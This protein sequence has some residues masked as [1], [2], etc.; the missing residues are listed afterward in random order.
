MV[1][2]CVGAQVLSRRTPFIIF[3]PGY[4]YWLLAEVLCGPVH[5]S[6]HEAI[7]TTRHIVKVFA[8]NATIL[9]SESIGVVIHVCI[10]I[11]IQV[12]LF[13]DETRWVPAR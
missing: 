12:K 11:S 1:L 10:K 4:A 8:L 7:T 2:L 9:N 6:A 3:V 5:G 13:G